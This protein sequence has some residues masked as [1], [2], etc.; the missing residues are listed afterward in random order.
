MGKGKTT[1]HTFLLTACPLGRR[2]SKWPGCYSLSSLDGSGRC[3][4]QQC[5]Q[6]QPRLC[7]P[8][9]YQRNSRNPHHSSQQLELPPREATRTHSSV[10]GI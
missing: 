8:S 2:T 4:A 5:A 6:S 9:S 3:Q 1:G 7:T 10:L